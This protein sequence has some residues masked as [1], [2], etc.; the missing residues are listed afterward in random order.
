[1]GQPDD[2]STFLTAVI[3]ASAFKDHAAYIDAAAQEC[4][5]LAGG[6][7]DKSQGYFVQPTLIETTNPKSTTMVQ[8]ISRRDLWK[9]KRAR[10]ICSAPV[11][12]C[13]MHLP[14]ARTSQPKHKRCCGAIIAPS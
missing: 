2:F 10:C 5:I 4:T 7:Y 12:L 9:H 13:K 8:E 6:K 14:S 11:A 1:M 3:D